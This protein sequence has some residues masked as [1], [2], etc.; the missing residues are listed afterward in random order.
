MTY[1][2][3]TNGNFID[4]V[5]TDN[6]SL[7]IESVLRSLHNTSRCVIWSLPEDTTRISFVVDDI[8]VDNFPLSE[9]D[10]DGTAIDS[11]DDFETGITAMFTGLSP[12]PS[13]GSSYLVYTALWGQAATDAPSVTELQNTIVG[14]VW[15][16]SSQGRYK[17]TNAGAFTIGKTYIVGMSNYDGNW[18]AVIPVGIS[19]GGTPIAGYFNMYQIS[20]DEIAVDIYNDTGGIVEY[21]T[22]LGATIFSLPEIRVYP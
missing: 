17:L 20:V 6:T 3:R 8:R 11:Q 19:G 2:F 14:G 15:S 22:L 9:I 21:S 4:F 10:F 13:P 1:S 12:S 7:Q 18:A 5:H 16:R